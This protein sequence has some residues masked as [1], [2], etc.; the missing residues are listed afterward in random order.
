MP[1]AAAAVAVMEL[2]NRTQDLRKALKT[3]TRIGR[4]VRERQLKRE[5]K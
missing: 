5:G 1:S 4:R 2:I 3:Q